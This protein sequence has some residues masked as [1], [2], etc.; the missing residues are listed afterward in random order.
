MVF[1]PLRLQQ[2]VATRPARG[3]SVVVIERKH[4]GHSEVYSYG[5][6]GVVVFLG[7]L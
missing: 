7:V 4:H 6:Q 2:V 3:W 5:V 1:V